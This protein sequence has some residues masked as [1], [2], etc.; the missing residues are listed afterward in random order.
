MPSASHA[1]HP[2]EQAIEHY[3]PDG[4]VRMAKRRILPKS[5]LSCL[6]SKIAL[7]VWILCALTTFSGA[8]QAEQAHRIL[9]LGGAVTEIVYALGQGDR[10]IA[11]D[12]TSTYPAET[13]NLESVGYVRALSPEGVLSVNPDLIIATEGSG[14]PE[15]LDVLK[16]ASI[17]I[18]TIPEGYDAN[19]VLTKI[20]IVSEA[21]GVPE[22][23]TRLSEH[24][25]AGLADA[26]GAGKTTSPPRVLFV[27]SLQGG[28]I[29][30]AGSD[31]AAEGIIALSGGKNALSGFEGYQQVSEEAVLLAEPDVILMMDRSGDH[32]ASDDDISAHPVLG[33]TPAAQ[34]GAV[35]RLPGSLLLGFGPRTPQAVQALSQAFK[36]SKG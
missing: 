8:A 1:G 7:R 3:Q 18:V 22:E 23:G 32:A 6:R 16:A 4:M 11:R 29:L 13:Q 24:V 25:S 20:A 36:R 28:R 5:G 26:I 2:G 21:L 34:A 9:S 14:P 27:L 10:L 12:S 17:P 31:T 15:T 35:V 33:R 19:A 30:A